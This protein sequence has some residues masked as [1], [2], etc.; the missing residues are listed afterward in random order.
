M[1]ANDNPRTAI[2]LDDF[3][4]EISVEDWQKLKEGRDQAYQDQ[5]ETAARK[6]RRIEEKQL[7]H[8]TRSVPRKGLVDWVRLGMYDA[9]AQWFFGRSKTCM[10]MPNP[11]FPQPVFAAAWKPGIVVCGRPSCM[12]LLVVTG[13]A[14]K[15]CDGCGHICEG[16]PDDG[17][18]PVTSFVGS[19]G[20]QVGVC[21]D[22]H[23]EMK[24]AEVEAGAE[25][26]PE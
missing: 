5:L 14:N 9:L 3:L 7:G 17:I 20:Y 23:A 13:V 22:C 24:R 10:H 25:D 6:A 16:L 21:N 15:T 19:L 18:T 2:E 1:A 12:N 4:N 11:Q 8:K 26:A